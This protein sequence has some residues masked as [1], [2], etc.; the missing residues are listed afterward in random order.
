VQKCNF[1]ER[2]LF[3]MLNALVTETRTDRADRTD[4][5][6]DRTDRTDQSRTTCISQSF[7]STC[8][9]PLSLGDL[10]GQAGAG[11]KKSKRIDGVDYSGVMP[12]ISP[13]TVVPIIPA[14]HVS[15]RTARPRRCVDAAMGIAKIYFGRLLSVDADL[16]VDHCHSSVVGCQLSVVS[17][18]ED[19]LIG[20]E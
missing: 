2:P 14:P 13:C 6:D 17:R 7:D 5:T 9:K 20:A 3:T 19:E 1:G 8:C 12:R 4:R 11:S 10:R 15:P 16:S 18:C